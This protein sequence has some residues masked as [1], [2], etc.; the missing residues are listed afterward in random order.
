MVRFLT[1][2]LLISAV[3]LKGQ[4]E[5]SLISSSFQ[6]GTGYTLKG[7]L[8]VGVQN[9]NGQQNEPLWGYNA[10]VTFDFLTQKRTSLFIDLGYHLKGSSFRVN[11]FNQSGQVSQLFLGNKFHNLAL[12]LGAKSAWKIKEKTTAYILLGLRADFTLDYELVTYQG[13]DNYVNRFNY[14]MTVGGGV[15]FALADKHSIIVELQVNPDFSRQIQVPPG[16]FF[17]SFDRNYYTLSEQRVLNLAIELMV[18][19][20]FIKYKDDTNYDD[21]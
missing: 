10:G 2:F 21:F 6:A 9:W 11:S 8:T 1:F 5:G 14:G 15:E 17:N 13:M 4:D 18:G 7:G 3:Q 12:V 19:Y 16:R 20:K